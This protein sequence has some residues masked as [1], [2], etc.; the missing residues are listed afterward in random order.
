MCVSHGS[1]QFN[2]Q[3]YC[4]IEIKTKSVIKAQNLDVVIYRSLGWAS[5]NEAL[6]SSPPSDLQILS[7]RFEP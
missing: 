6:C 3:F 1:C 5:V 4:I 7:V 2:V